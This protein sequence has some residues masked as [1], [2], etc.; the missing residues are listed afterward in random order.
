VNQLA[1][2]NATNTDLTT[3][4]GVPYV[5]WNED[6]TAG[7]GSSSTIRVAR[8]SAN[9]TT[10]EKVGNAGTNP[11]SRLSSTSSEHPSIAD[12]GGTPWV[13]WDEGLTQNNSEIRVA[14]LNAAGT[15]WQRIP[16]T[17]RPVDH[18]RSDPGGL[19]QYPTIVGDGGSRPFVSFF[20]SDPGSGSLFFGANQ[21]PAKVYVMRLNA[22]GTGWDEV[23]GGPVNA[24]T[25]TDAAY[26][27]MTL[28]DGIPWVTYFQVVIVNNAPEIQLRVATLDAGGVWKQVGGVVLSGAPNGSIDFP[29]IASVG[30]RPYLA[31]PARL[32]ESANRVRV[33]HLDEAGTGWVGD[34]TASPANLSVEGVSLSDVGGVPWVAW[35]KHFGGDAVGVARWTNGAWQQAATPYNHGG[36]NISFGPALANVN[37]IPWFSYT[38]GDGQVAGG[39][40]SQGCCSQVRIA[41]LEPTFSDPSSQPYDTHATLLTRVET[42]GLPYRIGFEY[43]VGDAFD[44]STAATPAGTQSLFYQFLTGLKPSTLFNFRAYAT[45]GTAQPR[46]RGDGAYFVTDAASGDPTEPLIVALLD[47]R[48]KVR[49]QHAAKVRFLSTEAGTARLRIWQDGDVVVERDIPAVR[50][51]NVLT[52]QTRRGTSLGSY[53][54]SVKVTSAGGDTGRDRGSIEVLRH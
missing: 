26:P 50:G 37:G 25:D 7:G 30:G 39:Q 33:F 44:F 18:L 40:Q 46:V 52:W 29:D 31:V 36:G 5:V 34:G 27:R 22:A 13:A 12:V 2:R 43:G 15:A 45:A 14:R 38:E 3:V 49:R 4:G 35:R 23:G 19:A 17:L 54:V 32:N 41:R 10:W 1:T 8:L 48:D 9:G 42:Y 53:R 21:D 20:E 24:L 16:D 28:V 11:I 47:G 6:T 51:V